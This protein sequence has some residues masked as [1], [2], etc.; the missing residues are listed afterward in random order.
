[1]VE[2]AKKVRER[3]EATARMTRAVVALLSIQ[4]E[5]QEMTTIMMDGM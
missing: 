5:T 1:L 3:M 2:Y 4:N